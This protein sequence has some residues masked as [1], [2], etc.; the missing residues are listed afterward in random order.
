MVLPQYRRMHELLDGLEYI[1]INRRITEQ[2]MSH[3]RNPRND[4]PDVAVAN[5]AATALYS[6]WLSC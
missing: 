6:A 1:G 5:A 4:L 2:A 3:P